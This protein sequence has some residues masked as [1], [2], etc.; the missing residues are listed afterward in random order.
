[1]GLARAVTS[2]S[3]W[4]GPPTHRDSGEPASSWFCTGGTSP[5]GRAGDELGVHLQEV[6][7]PVPVDD[8]LD[9]RVAARAVEPVLELGR[10]P[11]VTPSIADR[12]PPAELPHAAKKDGVQVQLGG[13]RAQV[14]RRLPH[15]TDRRGKQ[16]LAGEPVLDRGDRV[17][18][19]EQRGRC[20]GS[21]RRS[22][23]M[24]APP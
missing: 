19:G 21:R 4:M 6:R 14:G 9:G 16:C 24:N 7:R 13:V 11:A 8:G 1:M 2:G 23:V 18:R 15:V 22:P 5:V 12:W 10:L 3:S 20:A 17:P